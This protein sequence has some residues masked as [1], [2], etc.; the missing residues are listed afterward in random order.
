MK[1]ALLNLNNLKTSFSTSR[2][3]TDYWLSY[4][5]QNNDLESLFEFKNRTFV[6]NPERTHFYTP[7]G[8]FN[9]ESYQEH[10]QTTQF[11]VVY[12]T[13]GIANTLFT[14]FRAFLFAY[15]GISAATVR[16]YDNTPKGQILNRLSTDMYAI[17]DSLP[18]ILN[19][20]LANMFGLFGTLVITC[21]SLPWFCLSL[22]PLSVIYYS[23]QNYYRW[24]SR[25]LKRLSS[26]S[27]SPLYTHCK[28]VFTTLRD[29]AKNSAFTTELRE[30]LFI[31]S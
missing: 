23:I 11:F 13:L 21:L 20:F 8:F 18:F 28:L 5:T 7:K 9:K 19:I 3:I 4:W 25:E 16:Y 27:L 10:D 22:I 24:T 14:L 1:G 6:L 2:N 29:K 17:D 12:G 30:K 15:S 31:S 26:V